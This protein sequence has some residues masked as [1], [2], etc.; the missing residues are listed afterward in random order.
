ME[1]GVRFRSGVLVGCAV[2]ALRAGAPAADPCAGGWS[3]H[4]PMGVPR[5]ETGTAVLGTRVYVVGGFDAA[6]VASAVLEVY[7]S[8]T[9]AW[10]MRSP[11]PA[12]LHHPAA[13]AVGDVLYV[14]GGLG[15]ATFDAVASTYAYDPA[16]DAW[17]ARAP[18]PTA[19]G[20]LGI[21][22]VEGRIYAVGGLRG[23]SVP[24]AAVYDPGSDRWTALP[25]MPTA[26]DHLA[27]AAVGGIV[28]AVGGRTAVLFDRLEAYDP[29]TNQWTS[30]EAMPTARGGLAAA[31][32][33]GRLVTFGGEGN[34]ADPLGI[35]RETEAWDPGADRWSR[36]AD[37]PTP[38]H[39]MA[40][41]TM[42][43]VV[44]VPGG[45]TRAGFGVSAANEAFTPPA[46]APLGAPRAR[47]ARRR[48]AAARLM[49]RAT[50]ARLADAPD[51]RL[52]RV[53]VLDGDRELFAATL[54]PGMLAARGGARFRHRDHGRPP[55]LRALDLR[56]RPGG[57]VR[58]VATAA[59][60]PLGALPN[61]ATLAV[62]VGDQAFCGPV[63][64]RPR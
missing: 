50:L 34:A 27:A 49:F 47:V 8:A 7:D 55:R 3:S 26:R 14:V 33:L 48:S 45:A 25:P 10:T 56:R 19:R 18:L 44:W 9:D 58:L 4:A 6:S 5:Q 35:F 63:R 36:L 53:R 59:P 30:R 52:L 39:G 20:A 28:Y 42:G 64:L 12:A 40:A 29:S 32:V 62:E 51:T 61:T 11:M 1:R 54:P 23:A 15:G 24:D 57:D 43:A 21:A 13:A 2:L 16:T 38:R 60:G 22:V 31:A 17:T 46:G 37:M 41:A